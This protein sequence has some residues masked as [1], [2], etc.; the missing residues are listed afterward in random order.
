MSIDPVLAISTI[1]QVSGP[2]TG[3]AVRA[4]RREASSVPPNSGTLPSRQLAPVAKETRSLELPP[5][6]IQ[7][8]RDSQNQ[9]IIKYLDGAGKV[10]C[11]VPS[12]Q[13]LALQEAIERALEQQTQ[14]RSGANLWAPSSV[15]GVRNGD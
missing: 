5:D 12:S 8:Q 15:Q 14:S 7:V 3:S 1:D 9:I 2:K 4:R 10:I 13:V 11:Q 6:V